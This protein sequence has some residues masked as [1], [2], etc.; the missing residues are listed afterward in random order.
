MA[1]LTIWSCE[2]VRAALGS[3]PQGLGGGAQGGVF[4]CVLGG[5]QVAVK[6]LQGASAGS[7]DTELGVLARVQ[8]INLLRILGYAK[9]EGEAYVV[10]ER[11]ERSLEA[12]LEGP[13]RLGVAH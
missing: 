10:Y 7:L 1:Q 13:V 12:A 2:A 3:A 8:N 9:G 11:M 6:H 4:A 5:T